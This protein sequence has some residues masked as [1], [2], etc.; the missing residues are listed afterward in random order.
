MGRGMRGTAIGFALVGA[1]ACGGSTD[2]APVKLTGTLFFTIDQATCLGTHST[3]FEIDSTEVGPE[4]LAPGA[5]SKGYV[6]TAEVHATK[7]RIMNYFGTQ[8]ALWTTNLRL[9]VPANGTATS[10]VVC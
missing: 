2:P 7:A 3:Y 6:A 4:T 9:K 10:R 8:A 1:M 5:T